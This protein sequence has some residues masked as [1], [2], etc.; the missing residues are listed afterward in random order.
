MAGEIRALTVRQ[1]WVW[2]I[3]E[4]G[5][6]IENRTWQTAY[7]GLLAIHA[8]ARFDD[9]AT[10]PVDRAERRLRAL[11]AKI[12][13]A[14]GSPPDTANLRLSRII[15]VA[16]LTGIHHASECRLPDRSPIPT[17]GDLAGGRPGCSPWAIPGEYHWELGCVRPLPDPV[18][19]KGRLG[20]WRLPEDVEKAVRAQLEPGHA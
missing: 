5:K 12:R 9:D 3:A 8:G 11:V 7:R 1:P 20:L 16:D 19:C 4:Q 15:A 6:T 17:L 18:P 10:M 2:A 13:L 14:H